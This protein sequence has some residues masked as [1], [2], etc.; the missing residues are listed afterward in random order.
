[1]PRRT[2]EAGPDKGGKEEKAKQQSFNAPSF[3]LGRERLQGREK[4]GGRYAVAT[5]I[6]FMGRKK[7]GVK[8]IHCAKRCYHL[9]FFS[10]LSYPT[11]EGRRGKPRRR[12]KGEKKGKKR[13]GAQNSRQA[14]LAFILPFPAPSSHRGKREIVEKKRGK[15]VEV[16]KLVGRSLNLISTS[17]KERKALSANRR[18]GHV[19]STLS[20]VLNSWCATGG[21]QRIEAEKGGEEGNKKR[22]AGEPF[23]SSSSGRI[24]P[25]G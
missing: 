15:G 24:L 17:G 14:D 21:L 12:R 11:A 1:L 19:P 6:F 16:T 10:I 13:R 9:S 20:F 2:Y 23:H 7:E 4:K 22:C 18:R 8:S 25:G 5:S 3:H